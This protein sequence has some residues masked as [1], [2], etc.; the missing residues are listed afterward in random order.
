MLCHRL[1]KGP[2]DFGYVAEHRQRNIIATVTGAAVLKRMTS[3]EARVAGGKCAAVDKERQGRTGAGGER[4]Y[5]EASAAPELTA[6][7]RTTK[8]RADLHRSSRA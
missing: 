2:A 1:C 6:P 8:T 4:R 3:E 7:L 5:A